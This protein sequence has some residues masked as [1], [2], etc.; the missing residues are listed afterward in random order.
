MTELTLS[1]DL[2]WPTNAGI[3]KSRH[4]CFPE[5]NIS[6]R[7]LRNVCKNSSSIRLLP[8]LQYNLYIYC[9][10]NTSDQERSMHEKEEK[11]LR[12]KV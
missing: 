8:S 12:S 1:S 2:M 3:R 5:L 4:E 7:I 11:I 6:K 9:G 10:I